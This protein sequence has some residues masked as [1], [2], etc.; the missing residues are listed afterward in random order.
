MKQIA[1]YFTSIELFLNQIFLPK[2]PLRP[3][4]FPSPVISLHKVHFKVPLRL[5][6]TFTQIHVYCWSSWSDSYRSGGYWTCVS[7]HCCGDDGVLVFLGVT[8]GRVVVVTGRE[9]IGGGSP[10]S[11]DDDC[12]STES[13]VS[14]LPPVDKLRFFWGMGGAPPFLAAAPVSAECLESRCCCDNCSLILSNDDDDEG[15]RDKILLLLTWWAL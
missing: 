2:L 5:L 4:P 9:G 3:P 8:T 15:C 11:N 6:D 1:A 14:L 13:W 12:G 7:V 10:L